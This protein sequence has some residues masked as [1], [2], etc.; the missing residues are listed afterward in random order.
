MLKKYEEWTYKFMESWKNLDGVK[1]TNLISE[2]AKYYEN[3]LD[4][5]CQDRDEIKRLWEIVP[6]NQKDIIYSF[7]IIASNDEYTIINFKME[8]IFIPNNEK[9][10]IDGIFQI[11]LNKKGLCNY[12]KQ[13]RFTENEGI[14]E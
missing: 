13:W 10:Y 12:F 11:S 5:P 6:T 1:T 14:S 2:D 4:K 9:Q 3:P 7:D 8:R